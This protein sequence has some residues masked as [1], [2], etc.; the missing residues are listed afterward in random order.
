VSLAQRDTLLALFETCK[1]SY[2]QTLSLSFLGTNY[3]GL[4][5]DSDAMEFSE[6][7]IGVITGSVKLATV[8]RLADTG[9][10][11]SDFPM[12][13]SGARV[14]RPYTHSRN[15]DTVSVRTEGGR[16]AYARQAA[17]LRTW[18]A[19]GPSI[20]TTE[21][22]AIWDMFRRAAGQWRSFQFTDP[23]SLTAYPHCRFGSD[24]L[25]WRMNGPNDNA[26]TVTIQ[27]LVA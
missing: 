23:D 27:E 19:G 15:F 26:I 5:F 3:T 14:Q 21:A 24:S 13:S 11:P 20:S 12:L 18:S 10:F 6:P 17:G 4:Y 8:V 16:F 7:A 1:G 9:T 2:N 25:D 22:T